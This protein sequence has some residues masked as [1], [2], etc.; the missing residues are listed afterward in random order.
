LII[1]EKYMVKD[2]YV[3]KIKRILREG[4]FK[5]LKEPLTYIKN[6]MGSWYTCLLYPGME[7]I[8]RC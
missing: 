8:N 3:E 6:G 2:E 5:E 7:P 4:E 1:Y